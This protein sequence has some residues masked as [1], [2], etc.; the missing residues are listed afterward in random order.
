MKILAILISLT[1]LCS[2]SKKSSSNESTENTTVSSGF[3]DE[4]I[5]AVNVD[6]TQ[7]KTDTSIPDITDVLTIEEGTL[8]SN[9]NLS[10]EF[11]LARISIIVDQN[12]EDSDHYGL[13]ISGEDNDSESFS[14]FLNE[15]DL[16]ISEADDKFQV[17]F[18][19]PVSFLL[20]TI[21]F[22]LVVSDNPILIPSG[23]IPPDYYEQ[24]L[25]A[26]ES[27]YFQNGTGVFNLKWYPPIASASLIPEGYQINYRDLDLDSSL[28]D[29]CADGDVEPVFTTDLN[30]TFSDLD[31]ENYAFIVCSYREGSS[32]TNGTIAREVDPSIDI[33]VVC[34]VDTCEDYVIDDLPADT[35]PPPDLSSFNAV[36]GTNSGE[37]DLTWVYPADTSDIASITIRRLQSAT[38]PTDCDAGAVAYT[39]TSTAV[40]SVTDTGLTP[41]SQYSYRICVYDDG[42]TNVTSG[43]ISSNVTAKNTGLAQHTI[44]IA[45]VLHA[46]FTTQAGGGHADGLAGGDAICQA[47]ADAETLGGTWKAILST[48][49]ID[50]KDRISITG[51]VYNNHPTPSIAFADETDMWGNNNAD[52]NLSYLA[53]GTLDDSYGIWSGSTGF[54]VLTTQYPGNINCDDWTNNS[55]GEYTSEGDPTG[56]ATAG[57]WILLPSYINA[58]CTESNGI[59]CIDQ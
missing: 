52:S 5:N 54:G 30:Y 25:R 48:T 7:S 45:N 51:P 38:A 57:S 42:S 34:L 15:V 31:S 1:I 28:P 32:S 49:T 20:K 13:L 43:L 8:D 58:W 11:S 35:T 27:A 53:D 29:S 6:V 37:I 4:K 50:A 47:A 22:K 24:I 2:C 36:T 21:N 23:F 17:F 16:D 40:T 59:Y 3:V 12:P 41:G 39:T 9:N 19:V 46:D 18:V 33:N 26:P 14:Y 10:A 44:F 55:R 56:S